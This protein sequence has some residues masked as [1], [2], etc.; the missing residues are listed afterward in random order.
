[1]LL[2]WL[3]GK[4]FPSLCMYLMLQR[5]TCQLKLNSFKCEFYSKLGKYL[6]NFLSDII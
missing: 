5:T 2:I 4:E 3:F 6:V 1:M